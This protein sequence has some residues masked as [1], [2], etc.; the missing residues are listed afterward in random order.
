MKDF[1]NK[2][3]Q[4]IMLFFLWLWTVGLFTVDKF[5]V[6]SSISMIGFSAIG[7]LSA[8]PKF[9]FKNYYNN[10]SFF[11]LGISFFILFPSH[12]YSTNTEY[13][14]KKVLLLLPY[15]VLPF[16]YVQIKPF[17]K[18]HIQ[19][20]INTFCIGVIITA[21]QA[22]IYYYNN[23]SEVNQAYLESR[24]M[25]TAVAH[26]PTFSLMCALAIYFLYYNF[27]NAEILR[28]QII[29]AIGAVLLVVFIHIFSVRAGLL[30]FYLLML[31]AIYEQVI[32]HKKIK[33]VVAM[34][35]VCLTVAGLTFAFS[36]TIRNK[37]ANTQNDIDNYQ[38]GKSVNNQ[39]LGSR[40]ISYKNAVEIASNTSVLFGCG[41]GDIED[42][43][44]QL[45]ATKY[46]EVSK[47]I[48]PH[49]QF[50][51]YYAAIGL[52]GVLVF[53][54]AFYFPLYKNFSNL[55]LVAQYIVITVAFLIE[56]FL[57]TQ[58]GVSFS[59]LFLLLFINNKQASL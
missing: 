28:Y 13:L 48:I 10:K 56:A 22:L 26:H 50:L 43:N 29:N 36:P 57:T 49:N 9:W 20:I 5:R 21:V 47:R 44:N 58:L 39:S 51:F 12:L 8:P 55:H 2:Y 35:V 17:N 40:I 16:T 41:L 31:L 23:A 34:V 59:L 53:I 15:F 46:P 27:K 4:S 1:F 6:L 37:I 25:P 19:I 7:L 54:L 33:M 30:A 38:S 14:C 18:D 52:L 24:V 11:A 45:F 32:I 3:N 42:L